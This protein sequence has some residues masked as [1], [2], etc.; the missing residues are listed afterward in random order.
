MLLKAALAQASESFAEAGIESNLADAEILLAFSLGISRADLLGK[1]FLAERINQDQLETFEEL[2]NKRSQRIPLQHLTGSAAFRFLELEVGPGVFIP[3]F[4]TEVVTSAALDLLRKKNLDNPVVVDLATGSGAIALSIALEVPEAKVCAV[5]LSEAALE[6]TRKNFA[7]YSPASQL[8]Q[9]DLKDAFPELDGQ[10]DLVISNPP[11]IPKDMVPI[12]PE[13]H[14]HDPSLALY[15]GDDGLD[16]IRNV[17]RSA[18]RLLKP[19]AVLVIE[20]A[21]MQAE[22]VRAILL[23]KGWLEVKTGQDLAG[24]DRMVTAVKQ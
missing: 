5:E 20:H 6:Y 23:A 8:V 11:Y 19:G 17:E 21:D 9:G 15:G 24:R 7:K 16:I 13:V 4:E 18:A 22:A 3:R 2:V 1:I 10:V 14:L 12:Y